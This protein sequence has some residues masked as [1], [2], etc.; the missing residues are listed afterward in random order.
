MKQ[1]A[2]SISL[3]GFFSLVQANHSAGVICMAIV[4]LFTLPPVG[5]EAIEKPH[6]GNIIFYY[7]QQLRF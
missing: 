6:M 7:T 5:I 4:Y 1:G 2:K 3:C